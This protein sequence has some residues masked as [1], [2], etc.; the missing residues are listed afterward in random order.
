VA[1]QNHWLSF[2]VKQWLCLF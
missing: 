2:W 1:L